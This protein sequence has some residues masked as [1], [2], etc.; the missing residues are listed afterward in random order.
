MMKFY[1]TQKSIGGKGIVRL[2]FLF[3]ILIVFVGQANATTRTWYTLADGSW[4]DAIWTLDPAGLTSSLP[5]GYTYPQEGDNVVILSGKT[6][7][8]PDGTDGT[9][10]FATNTVS[11][12]TVTIQGNLDV[13][14]F[15][16]FSF[17]TL[18][19]GGRLLMSADCYPSVTGEDYFSAE[20]EDEGTVV[21]EGSGFTVSNEHTFYNLEIALTSGTVIQK[22]DLT[23]NGNLLV[24]TGKL[25][26]NDNSSTTALNITVNGDVQ[27]NSGAK[28]T[29]GTANAKSSS[30]S[31]YHEMYHQFIVYGD[32]K[33]YGTVRFT[34]LSAPN[35]SSAASNGIVTLRFKGASDNDFITQGTTD[36]YDL[37]IDKGTDRSY[38][39]TVQSDAYD[40]FRLFGYCNGGTITYGSYS[41]EDPYMNK[42]LWIYRGTLK[43]TG[44][45]FIP[46]LTEGGS[47]Y[48]IGYNGKLWVA[49]SDVTVYTTAKSTADV[50]D[51]LNFSS[52][53][54]VSTGTQYSAFSNY[55]EFE[56]SAGYVDTR[57]GYG[58]CFYGGAEPVAKISG[59][60]FVTERFYQQYSSSSKLTYQQT[61]GTLTVTGNSSSQGDFDLSNS[62]AVF[63]M[64]GGTI[65]VEKGNFL[66]GSDDGNYNVTGGTVNLEA[67][68]SSNSYY[69]SST[70]NLW[71]VE[72]Q[73]SYSY[74]VGKDLVVANDLTIDNGSTLNTSRNGTAYDLSI[75]GDFTN[76]GTYTNNSNTTT[77][78]GDANST[79]TAGSNGIS[80]YELILDKD[81]A[82]NTVTL[83]DGTI[84]V[85]SDLTV[86]K[87]TL[88]IGSS[89][90]S[91]KGDV[92]IVNGQITGDSYMSLNGSSAQTIKG[93][94]GVEQEFGSLKLNNSNG[95]TLL[96][97]VNVTD[98]T[99]SSGMVNLDTYNLTVSGS[100]TGYSESDSKY[101]YTSGESSDGGL[102]LG[103][104]IDTSSG[105]VAT[106]PVA[107]YG[108][109]E[110]DHTYW[111]ETKTG[112][113]YTPATVTASGQTTSTSGYLT[114][115][116]VNSAHPATEDGMGSDV[117]AY[118]WKT[119]VTGFEDLQS[120]K[121]G[122]KFNYYE[123][124]DKSNNFVVAWLNGTDWTYGQNKINDSE[125]LS[126][127]SDNK[128]GGLTTLV[129]GDFTAGTINGNAFKNVDTYYSPG[130]GI[131]TDWGNV[132][133]VKADG[134]AY[135]KNDAPGASDIVVIQGK[136]VIT[137]ENTT[138]EVAE[139]Q[140]DH[141]T[142]GTDNNDPADLAR[143]RI[144]SGKFN[145]GTV[146]G[147]GYIQIFP[148]NS[149]TISGDFG[150]FL[151]EKYSVVNYSLTRDV[152]S[153]PSYF[154]SYPTLML[155]SSSGTSNYTFTFSSD[156][157]I[158]RDLIV[159]GSITASIKSDV[160]IENDLFIGDW[161]YG[162]VSFPSSTWQS[163]TLTVKGDIDMSKNDEG[164]AS[165][166]SRSLTCSG[167]SVSHKILVYGDINQ[168]QGKIV[169]KNVDLEFAGDK[170]QNVYKN[171]NY[172]TSL[173]RIIVDKSDGTEVYFDDDFTLSGSTNG[174]TKALELTSGI[175]HLDDSGI[176]INL[177]TG[178]A[179]FDI[180]SG[181]QLI[182][183]GES[184][185]N[186]SGSNT[187][188]WLDGLLKANNGGKIYC[189]DGSNNYIEYS[190][191]GN[192]KIWLGDDSKL[193]VG[194][195]IRRS[196]SMDVGILG[197]NQTSS[198][199]TVVIGED[200]APESERGVFEITGE[201]S[202]FKQA[203]DASITIVRA[204]TNASIAALYFDPDTV[205]IGDGAEFVLGN[206]NT[207]ASQVIR[208][209]AT[210]PMGGITV[211]GTN[212]PTAQTY[213]KDLTL[214]GDLTINSG[215]TYDANGL[216][217][218]IQGGFTDNGTFT[219]NK[220]NT[221]FNG[222]A[223]Q[224][225]AG[226]ASSIGFYNLEQD[227]SNTLNVSSSGVVVNN[228]LSINE[229]CTFATGANTVTV[230][231]DVTNDGT[232]SA[233]DDSEGILMEGSDTQQLAGSGTF[234]RLTIN[235]SN[236]VTLPT[237]G[238]PIYFTDF[239]KLED[240]IL[241]VGQNLLIFEEDAVI[242]D[243]DGN[244]SASYFSTSNMIQ[245][246]LSLKDNG[247]EKIYPAVS[248]TNYSFVY[249]IGSVDKYTPVTFTVTANGNNTGS[250]TVKTAD[251][252]H[253]TV[254]EA[255]LND[256][257][258]YYWTLDADGIEDMTAAVAMQG[259]SGDVSVT[260]DNEASDYITARILSANDYWNKYDE[261]DFDETNTIL[262]FTLEGSDSN[263]SGD[264]TAGITD[265]LPTTVATYITVDD[266]GN[267]KESA[268]WESYDPEAEATT[269]TAGP[270][271]GPRGCIAY[272]NKNVVM[273][274]NSKSAFRTIILEDGVVKVGT[275]YGHSLGTVTGTGTLQLASSSIPAGDYDE[276]FSKDGGTLEY[277]EN[278]NTSYDILGN[279]PQVNNLKVT[280][281]SSASNELRIADFT[282]GE[283]QILGDLT[284]NDDAVLDNTN[285]VN[286][287][288]GG[289]LIF[290]S[291][292][293]VPG[294]GA[295]MFNGS[296]NQIVS[297]S[298]NFTSTAGGSLYDLEVDN[299]YGV[300]IDNGFEVE[301]SND[302]IFT[303]GVIYTDDGGDLTITNTSETAGDG[304]SSSSYVQ[305]PLKKN[306]VN[307]GSYTFPVG[308]DSRYGE[309][310][311]VV[312]SNG[313]GI[314]EAQ[315]YNTN[316]VNNSDRSMDP[317]LFD[318]SSVAYVSHNEYWRIYSDAGSNYADV[319]IRW[320]DDSGVTADDNFEVVQ[321]TDKNNDDPTITDDLWEEKTTSGDSYDSANSTATRSISLNHFS[322]EGNYLTFGASKIPA[323]T[324]LGVSSNWFATTNW[325]G[326]KIP[327]EGVDI[328]INKT[329]NDPDIDDDSQV[330]LTH[331]LTIA[332]DASL[333]VSDGGMLNVSGDLETN[334]N[335]TI[336]NDLKDGEEKIASVIVQG[337]VG[338][339][340][341][342]TEEWLNVQGYF[343]WY[344]S[345]PV[346]GDYSNEYTNS[347]INAGGSSGS[348]IRLYNNSTLKYDY[349]ISGS[350]YAFNAL[351][352]FAYAVLNNYDDNTLSY[353]GT[354]NNQ[355]S[356]YHQAT[357]ESSDSY[358]QYIGNP[359]PSYID[360]E[361]VYKNSSAT[362]T[363]NEASTCYIYT[364]S[365]ES[366]TRGYATYNALQN[367]YLGAN[368]RYIAPGQ[369]LW[370][371]MNYGDKVYINKSARTNSHDTTNPVSMK[372]T[373][374][375]S[376]VKPMI[377][378]ALSNDNTY[379]EVLV[380]GDE[381]NGSDNVTKYDSR[382]KMNSG[383]IGNIYTL[384]NDT[385]IAIN[386]IPEFYDGDIIPLGYS[387]SSSG[388]TDFTIKVSGL[389]NV[390]DYDIY[391]DDLEDGTSTNLKETDEYTFTPT[392]ASS[393][394]R[395]QIRIASSESTE[396]E[397]STT[398]I[399]DATTSDNISVYSS[400]KM[401]YVTVSDEWLQ[402]NS[403]MIYVYDVA[404]QLV[405]TAD[406]EDLETHFTLP[407]EGIF[408]IKVVSGS[409][410]YNQ[411]V[412]GQ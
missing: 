207:P 224:T 90:R 128:D 215:G 65:N 273:S 373:S 138:V 203:A 335:L 387:V 288:V 107:V 19:G 62:G 125:V 124:I 227:N 305:G 151:N 83:G 267:W 117:L 247:V 384:K 97:N 39:L 257:L 93:K 389:T 79:V 112:Y 91:V 109:Y 44:S 303:D 270:D 351:D 269:G 172:T 105:T 263:I 274:E 316:P 324:W 341:T 248:G 126:F 285:N 271:G 98:F 193:Y 119:K 338:S 8:V 244:S 265:A 180:P 360:F 53:S 68:N 235:N 114:V 129:D 145:V 72:I 195:Q 174:T 219:S 353:S 204:Q 148:G 14:T 228:D 352:A 155:E 256:V 27:V 314:Y 56:L 140:F 209:Y 300:T 152:N 313:A 240:G 89:A 242:E 374:S 185:V 302:L 217:L 163:Y 340:A 120:G 85:T 176:N 81:D 298:T 253:S 118:Y 326:G 238:D 363:A 20:D 272:V 187:G 143:L 225:I 104:T 108:T 121:V 375:S 376:S 164:T 28:I 371:Q 299:E 328:T 355:S 171:G 343:W 41:S 178:G 169:L 43:L 58:F 404:G 255:N 346:S 258:Q 329:S 378:L 168:Y 315:Y 189:N 127:G 196:T 275:T 231:G 400:G 221:Y 29:T 181:T 34:N 159:R 348:Y 31:T 95:L 74:L 345:N 101:F 156:I 82:D 32:F 412:L 123:D 281:K 232:T 359:Y 64:T 357:T 407:G 87:G 162:V 110:I 191:S 136:D 380:I 286:I 337:V 234:A 12:N 245:T 166:T 69:I 75:G 233:S 84:S 10:A 301:V 268:T 63:Y 88:D 200:G 23:L 135:N 367:V 144:K 167:S 393:D 246:N 339:T 154:D 49:G 366:G 198:S 59:G 250:I 205:S 80:F 1:L 320:D 287:Q 230:K 94:T 173:Y 142:T 157:T 149:P 312:A 141:D 408:L 61:G 38:V 201:G 354:F 260:G 131:N 158:H 383:V 342:A 401:A 368:A 330:A 216:D 46:T 396:E 405:Q 147:T 304:G 296:E 134:S 70:S 102:T 211:N 394:G 390:R 362:L 347:S 5:D 35:Y 165:Y 15:N 327:G 398:D 333:T 103:F 388:M 111:T 55:G 261:D 30:V 399:I 192:A 334:G 177:S 48:I 139:L 385:S 45:I 410:I 293:F 160:T 214:Q 382:K 122:L 86:T 282:S 262:N 370:V 365:T 116:P 52:V 311:V 184:T 100:L 54:G 411:K 6:V 361:E 51:N 186:V 283:I 364:T 76:N 292:T 252:A 36:L 40:H 26:I 137:V 350:S 13:G 213:I 332:S 115:I 183:D 21:Y 259:V 170:K 197:F 25:Q 406:L 182:V 7:T 71:D 297:G 280:G 150:A 277:V 18:K 106:F 409:M 220:N 22:K 179:D 278:A 4:N 206:N 309:V 42:A 349:N 33:N 161:Q 67:S 317:E 264:Y 321:W 395:F 331:D 386:S 226:T 403:R 78:I 391:L 50:T 294:T 11:Y 92:E 202:S 57:N 188:I 397:E 276:F 132:Q 96:S 284:I 236:D 9:T 336:E 24:K 377:R 402:S 369:C 325:Q 289:D 60:K 2:L 223:A 73:G 306:M 254:E 323:Y 210:Q 194:S 308:D 66:V 212:S 344:F 279:I 251:E 381:E 229:D 99:F 130:T 208:I 77:F 310:N 307:G 190:T 37:V 199:S 322:N 266:G 239:L 372:S 175:C 3:I 222:K 47:D 153:M 290:D 237:Q 318:E 356:Y 113:L 249:P 243:G 291:G 17:T 392:E 241:N 146:E 295:V 218:N 16:Y 133:W 358:Y 319:T 379:D